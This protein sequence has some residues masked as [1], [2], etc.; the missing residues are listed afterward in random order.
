MTKKV[1]IVAVLLTLVGAGT[2]SAIRIVA[3]NLVIIGSGG[4]APK[5]LPKHRDAPIRLFGGGRLTTLDGSLPPVLRT[6]Q[7][8]WDRHGH[9]ETR[10][11]PKCTRSRLEN[12]T[13][14]QARRNCP[15]AIVGTGFGKAIVKFP[16]QKAFPVS[17]P[18]TVFNGPR[19]GGD[20]TIFAHGYITVPVPTTYVVPV[21]IEKINKGRYGYRTTGTIP[22][23]AGGYGV[24]V[25]GKLKVG[26]MWRF[27][28]RRL[29]YV[30]A[31]CADGRLQARGRFVF[32]DGTI[33]N[34]TF[35]RPCTVRR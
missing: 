19:V 25:S 4:F 35:I 34:G 23:I 20:P 30:N 31:R 14:K 26:R 8:E 22:R 10:G 28:G 21:R 29:S 12:T 13:V 1:A 9:V 2:A 18:I 5:S 15:G 32:V 16:D 6:I 11:L 27:K 17:S 24:P 3:G 7:L 33:L